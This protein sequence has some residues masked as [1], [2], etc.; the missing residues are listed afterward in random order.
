MLIPRAPPAMTTGKQMKHDEVAP[1][2]LS[3][4]LRGLKPR[5]DRLA[6]K[7]EDSGVRTPRDFEAMNAWGSKAKRLFLRDDTTLSAFEAKK[8]ELALERLIS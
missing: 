6:S 7:L 4:F 8:V 5:L 1:P 2:T 3:G